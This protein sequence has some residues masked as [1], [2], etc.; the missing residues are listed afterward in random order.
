MT[1][2][3]VTNGMQSEDRRT[4]VERLN[5]QRLGVPANSHMRDVAPKQETPTMTDAQFAEL[6]APLIELLTPGYELSKLYLAQAQAQQNAAAA[7]AARA[8]TDTGAAGV[9]TETHG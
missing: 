4:H 1:E 9:A 8:A 2:P 5:P 7:A 6:R 3:T